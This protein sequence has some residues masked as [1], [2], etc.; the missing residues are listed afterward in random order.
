MIKGPAAATIYGTEAANG[1]IQIITKKGASSGRSRIQ[2]ACQTGTLY[3]R[4]AENRMPT[5]YFKDK[6]RRDRHMERRAS[7]RTTA[8]RRSSRPV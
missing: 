3:F 5:N 1:V 4:D 7:R 6:T 8:E 2:R